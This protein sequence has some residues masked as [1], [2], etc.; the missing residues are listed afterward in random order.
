MTKFIYKFESIK[1]IKETQ[2][3]KIRKEVS[4]IEKDIERMNGKLNEVVLEIEKTKSSLSTRR[5]IKV[6]EWQ[7][8][9]EVEHLLELDVQKIKIEIIKLEQTKQNKINEL[10]EKSKEHKMFET[11]EDKYQEDFISAQNQ[12][13]QKNIDEM[14]VTKFIREE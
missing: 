11:L 8:L 7:F 1:K 2:E 10:L 12:L 13:E 9:S 5:S 6:S 14:A 3:K 4:L